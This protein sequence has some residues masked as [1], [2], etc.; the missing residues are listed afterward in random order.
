LAPSS[1]TDSDD[2]FA[3]KESRFCKGYQKA[4]KQRCCANGETS[5]LNCRPLLHTMNRSLHPE[6][7]PQA[8]ARMIVV[9]LVSEGLLSQAAASSLQARLAAGTLKAEDWRLLITA[10][11]DHEVQP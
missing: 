1:G 4:R 6:T 7:P 5:H 8:L 3:S 11:L 10:G 9:R 2:F